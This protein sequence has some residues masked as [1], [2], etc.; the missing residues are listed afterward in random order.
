MCRAG[1]AISHYRLDLIYSPKG[2]AS[3]TAGPADSKD[4]TKHSVHDVMTCPM[5]PHT[6]TYLTDNAENER[7]DYNNAHGQ[8]GRR[9]IDNKESCR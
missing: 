9:G 5:R 2:P 4:L 8:C 3:G 1:S 6:V 7:P